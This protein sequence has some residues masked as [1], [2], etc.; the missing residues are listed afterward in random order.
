MK[1]LANMINGERKPP[2]TEVLEVEERDKW[3]GR[4]NSCKTV[5]CHQ[6]STTNNASRVHVPTDN[7]RTTFKFLPPKAV[8]WAASL[9]EPS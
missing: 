8:S 9:F 6:Q 7:P 5:D 4:L 3:W 2:N 1:I